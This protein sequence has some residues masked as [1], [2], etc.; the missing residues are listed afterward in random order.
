M[1]EIP[2]SV[3]RKSVGN[4]PNQTLLSVRDADGIT[5]SQQE[6]EGWSERAAHR[7]GLLFAFPRCL[8]GMDL[9]QGLLC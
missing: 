2:I 7:Q 8:S 1:S 5:Q 4:A 9:V 3:S 6:C